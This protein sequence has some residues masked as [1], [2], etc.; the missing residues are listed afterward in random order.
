MRFFWVCMT[1]LWIVV[2]ALVAFAAMAWLALDDHCPDGMTPEACG[3]YRGERAD[4]GT[5]A[6]IALAWL[7]VVIAGPLLIAR[8]R[9]RH[10]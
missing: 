3:R 10:R 4:T 6:V 9:T 1:L 2:S 7:V 8:F 5:V